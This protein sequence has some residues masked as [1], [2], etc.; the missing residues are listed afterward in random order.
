MTPFSIWPPGS[1]PLPTVDTPLGSGCVGE[2]DAVSVPAMSRVI[3]GA[4]KPASAGARFSVQ[5]AKAIDSTVTLRRCENRM[6]CAPSRVA[7]RSPRL[8]PRGAG[9][10]IRSGTDGV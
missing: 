5:A 3:T 6:V 9:W 2:R 7:A 1:P 10:N 8:S 4:W